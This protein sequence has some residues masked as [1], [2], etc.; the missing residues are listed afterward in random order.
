VALCFVRD[1]GHPVCNDAIATGLVVVGDLIGAG[2]SLD[3][4]VIGETPTGRIAC[5]GIL[6]QSTEIVR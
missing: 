1:R 6:E 2:S 5:A 4:A 3:Q